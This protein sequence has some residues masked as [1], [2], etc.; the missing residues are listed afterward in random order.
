[1]RERSESLYAT[2]I[3]VS[4]AMIV[5]GVFLLM[6]G[7]GSGAAQMIRGQGSSGA[8]TVSAALGA[9][10]LLGGVAMLLF[11]VISGTTLGITEKRGARKVDPHTRV[12]ARYASNS[13]GDTLTLES[14][15]PDPKTQFFV[16]MELGN[17]NRVEFQCVREVFDQCGEGMKGESH[18]QGRWLGMFRPYIGTQPTV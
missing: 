12:L 3:I 13:R 6:I 4:V 11:V 17:G 7:L 2:L 16:R 9:I 18:Y 5:G 8:S 1:M 15:Y 10:G 14:E